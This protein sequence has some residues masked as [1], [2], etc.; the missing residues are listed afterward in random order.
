MDHFASLPFKP[1][2]PKNCDVVIETPT[3]FMDLDFSN[4]FLF[5]IQIHLLELFLNIWVSK[6]QPFVLLKALH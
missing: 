3:I 6:I 1:S 2:D 4:C 5:F